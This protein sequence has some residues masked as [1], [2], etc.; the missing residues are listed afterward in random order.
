MCAASISDWYKAAFDGCPDSL[1]ATVDSLREALF[2]S[3][4]L[5]HALVA[6][7]EGEIVGMATYYA[8][9]SSFISKSGLWL[10]DLFVQEP[11]RNLGIGE[12]LM[13]RLCSIA[14][15]AGCGRVDWHVLHTNEGGKRF[16]RRLGAT[17]SERER[18]VRMAEG[19]IL[20]LAQADSA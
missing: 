13:R 18:L 19:T 7:V 1:Q 17:V 10:D 9:F 6:D 5:A 16:Y 8:I 2:S 11:S 20:A 4:P 14:A 12:A 3:N 15:A